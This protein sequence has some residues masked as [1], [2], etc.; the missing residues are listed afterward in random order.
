MYDEPIVRAAYI[1]GV[2]EAIGATYTELSAPKMRELDAWEA[3]LR[4]WTGGPPPPGPQWWG[5]GDK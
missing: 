2:V 3:E 5:I 4:L 1:A